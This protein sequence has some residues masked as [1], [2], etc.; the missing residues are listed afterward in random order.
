VVRLVL[1][2]LTP[3]PESFWQR[4]KTLGVDKRIT[5]IDRPEAGTLLRMY[6]EATVFALPSDEEGFGMVLL[7]AM[8]C[9]VPVVSTLSGGPDAIVTNGKDG[10]LVPRN[11]VAALSSRLGELLLEPARAIEMGD[12]ARRTIE[13]RYDER[14]LGERFIGIWDRLAHGTGAA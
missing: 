8:A 9:G 10:Y 3:P 1:A 2:G 14:V 5:Y 11:D 7:E 6:Q 12:A 13:R 4:V